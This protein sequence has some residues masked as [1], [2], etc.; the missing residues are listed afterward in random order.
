MGD[1]AEAAP[2]ASLKEQGNTAFAAKEYA[3]AVGL[4]SQALELEP[5]NHI[6][7]S[8][9]SAA[10]SSNGEHE[11]A[12]ED[13]RKCITNAPSFVKGHSRLVKALMDLEQVEDARIA[14]EQG[15]QLDAND[16]QLLR[17]KQLLKRKQT[18]LR[19]RQRDAPVEDAA[20]WAAVWQNIDVVLERLACYA[21][22][23]NAC[24]PSE[25]HQAFLQFLRLQSTSGA[26]TPMADEFSP[27]MMTALP[28]ENY[29]LNGI[30]P[31]KPWMDFFTALVTEAKI[32]VLTKMWET[33][34]EDEKTIIITDL[35]RFFLAPIIARRE[36]LAPKVDEDD[37]DS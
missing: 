9:R 30:L 24:S 28:T 7:F 17:L 18:E 5:E 19:K 37:D 31:V 12:A 3:K 32:Q 11:N 16:K 35:Q 10:Y 14:L 26:V 1:E 25:R 20:A 22:F 13:A 21:H 4:Y 2:S 6:Y 36:H 8:N 33:T 27:E 15:L 29:E 34:A 23:W